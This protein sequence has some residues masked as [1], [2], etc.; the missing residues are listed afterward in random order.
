MDLAELKFVVDTKDL[1]DAAK[2]VADLGTEVSKLNKPLQELSRESAKTN[3]ELSKA[4]EA[5]A[6]AALAQAKLEQ[7]QTK[8][9]QAA[10]KSSSVLERQNLILEYMAQGNSKGQASILA[11]AK[12]AGALDDEMLELNK[13]LITQRTLIGGDPFDKS[14]GLMQK[15]QNEYKITTEVTNLFNKN[16]GLTEKQMTDLAREKERLIALYGIEGKSLT[17]L[18]N[19]YDLLIQKSVK[20]NQANDARTASMKA[21]IKAQNDGAKANEYIANEMQRV[22]RLNAESADITSATNNRL[23][24][25]ER[26]LKASGMSAAE[27]AA[28][29]EAYKTAL[30]STQRAAGNRQVDYLSRALGPQITD[31]AVGLA[32][33]QAPLTI[34]LQQGGQLRDQFALAGVAGAD[35]GK[36]LIQA[37]KSMV[38]SVKDVGIAIGQVFVGA[39]TGSGKAIINFGMQ[40]TGTSALLDVFRTKLVSIDGENGKLV[41]SFDKLSKAFPAVIGTGIFLALTTI[42]ALIV[43]YSKVIAAEKELTKSLALSGAALG[44]STETAIEYA[45][46]M[47]SVDISTRDAMRVISEFANT[48]TEASIPLKEIIKSAIDM[49]KYVGIASKDTT[50]AFSDIAE[51]PVEGLIKLAKSTGNVSAATI[52]QAEAFV[53]AGKNAEAAKLAQ[54]ALRDSNEEVVRRM[55]NDLDPLQTLWLDI[56]T[57]V[58]SAS[59]AI[60]DLLKSSTSVA[61]FRTVWETVAVIATEVWY[62]IKQTGR[63]ISG[64]FSQ[65]KAVMSGDFQGAANIGKQM[66]AD[67]AIAREEQDKLIA[68]IMNRNNAEKETLKLTEQQRK[69]NRANAKEIEDRI[70]KEKEKPKAETERAIVVPVSRDIAIVQ[71]DYNEQLKL[72]EGFAKDERN[73]LKARF[74]AGLIDRAEFIMQDAQLLAR[75][76]QKQLDVIESFKNKYKEAYDAQAQLLTDA[77]GRTKDDENRRVLQTAIENLKK[78]FDEFNNTLDD[79]KTKIGSAFGAREQTM[80]LDFQKVAFQSTKTFKE[81][82]KS[83][84]DI[85]TNRA[86]DVELQ[87]KLANAYGAEAA[88]IKAVA[89][90]TKRQTVELSKFTMAQQLA[91]ESYQRT[92][93]DPNASGAVRAEAYRAYITAMEN[94]NNAISISRISIE[95]AGTDAIVAY[96]KQ[97]YQRISNAISDSI[98]SALFEGGKIGRKKLRDL[99]VAELKKPITIVVKALVDATL[100]NL[101]QSFIGGAV[102]SSTGS[103]AGSAAGSAATGGISNITIGGATLASQAGAFGQGIAS[104][105]SLGAPVSSMG[106]ATSASFNMGATYGAPVAG[107]LAGTAINRGISNGYKLNNTVNAIQDIGTVIASAIN[108]VFGVI[109]G[110]ASGVFNRLFGRKLTG[111]GIRGTVG[112]ETGFEGERYTFSKGGIFRRNKT[113]TSLL[114]EA[115][116]SAIASDFRLIKTSVM[117]L[118][119]TAGFGSDSIKNFTSSFQINLKGLTPEQAVKAYQAEF[120]RVEEAMAKTVIGTSNYR[121]ENE[122]NIQ[123]LTR[124]SIFMGGVNTVFKK[125]GFETYK[126]ELASIDAA[127]SFVD[128]FGGIEQFNKATGFFY[129][130]FFSVEERM[131]NLAADLTTEF[132]KLGLALP[133]TREEFRA[134]VTAAKEVG[135]DQQVK[136]LLDLQYAFAD[137]VPA[138][139]SVAGA[140]N[141]LTDSSGN[142]ARSLI[143]ANRIAAGAGAY[144]ESDFMMKYLVPTYEGYSSNSIN[145]PL[146]NSVSDYSSNN[147]SLLEAMVSVKEEITEL[148]YEVQADVTQNAKTATILTRVVPDGESLN[149]TATIDGG[150]V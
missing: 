47:N 141:D 50:K 16:L 139:E 1:E 91:F 45:K 36:M 58:S 20:L 107:A 62:V 28:K 114:E 38:S 64:I 103:F 104:G 10:G 105:F 60:Y 81:Y 134:L 149:V 66:K 106:S 65:I 56:K 24:R 34:L 19:E 76:E 124:L 78:D 13:T 110:A 121:R 102:G 117:D 18:S 43:E 112:G 53:K 88:K 41:A 22:S 6:K 32:T 130:N 127:Q 95:N 57:G 128:L 3:K 118:A 83:Q 79:T 74:D 14:I 129:E 135:D 39:I 119:E 11:T 71:K 7:A 49:E 75:S 99:I 144:M 98:V 89:D 109:A 48:G 122:T 100:G 96:Y 150:V 23:I 67:A 21:Q 111:V 94:A 12:A 136:N 69:E 26:E 37:S 42:I 133:G 113:T 85:A 115:D 120:A 125:L 147:Q 59:Q 25:F 92:L 4:E 40:I 68:S 51:K 61:I 70:K 143:E 131:T 84:E 52:L 17:G 86:I 73:I 138:A 123:T 5:A 55:K 9:A 97:E 15:L 80:L 31:I 63:E 142:Y 2:K 137:L 54:E 140:I 101:I 90:E 126:L 35:M 44:M 93:N 108:P 29:L 145:M 8:S 132:D 87:D 46:S 116:R 33:G 146:M 82:A 27:A 30:L 148:R 72:A 77:L